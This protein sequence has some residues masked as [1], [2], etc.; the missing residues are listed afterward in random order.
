MK[1]VNRF[2]KILG[3]EYKMA[4][5]YELSH[6]WKFINQSLGGI[7]ITVLFSMMWFASTKIG[8]E[9]LSK[10]Y[11]ISYFFLVLIV[12][13]LTMDVSIKMVTGSII[14]GDFSKYLVKP[15]SY[16]TEALGVN[17]AVQTVHILF[18]LPVILAGYFFLNDYLIYEL[19]PYTVALFCI[20]VI[21]GNIL[22]FLMAQVFALIAFSVKQIYG[23]RNLYE[24]LGVIFSGEIIPYAALPLSILA[25]LELSP[26]RYMLSFPV[27]IL[28]GNMRMYELRFGFALAL[29]WIVIA[30]VIY[31]VG[32]LIGIKKYEAE[33]I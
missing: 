21:M 22:K 11:V 14:T 24:N 23:L 29:I 17:L 9:S 27:E 12:S 16:M 28:M 13:K 5:S 25:V 8:Y 3:R 6:I 2:F 10:E 18:V 20:A 30:F 7:L 33:G 19:T 15:F 1:K 31:K 4:I 26:F 32:Y